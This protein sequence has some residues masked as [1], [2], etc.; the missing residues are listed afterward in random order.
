MDHTNEPF[1]PRRGMLQALHVVADFFSHYLTPIS[2]AVV[3]VGLALVIAG[4]VRAMFRDRLAAGSNEG[5]MSGI[6]ESEELQV[7]TP[8]V[9]V[10]L[11][12]QTEDDTLDR[13]L[14]PFTIIPDRPRDRV[15]SYTV[16]PGDTLFAI[17]N[18]FGIDPNT[19]FWSNSETLGDNVHMLQNGINLF[20]LP[21]DG[22]YHK[23]DGQHTLQWIADQY[24]ADVNAII[25]SEYNELSGYSPA[26]IPPWGMRI[27]VPGGRRE[28]VDW[29][30]PIIETTDQSTGQVVRGFMPGMGGSCAAGIVGSGGTGSWIPPL[31]AY[32]FTQ[33]Y[34]PGH[35][36]VD[37]A[38]PV[39]TPVL[40][41]DSGVVIFSGWTAADWGYGILVVLD[42]GN[43][44]TTYYAHLSGTNVGCGQFVPRGGTVGYVGTTGRS[45]GP[46]LHFEMRW[47]HVPDNP[48]NYIGF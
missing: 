29:R 28:I 5:G 19:L 3:I 7:E 20:I 24:Q 22:V 12:S 26:D 32:A 9:N 34:Y 15:I 14:V 17:A 33:S 43:G 10:A 4:P 35:S 38:A 41:A 25:N 46:H 27:V 2:V 1:F 48:A 8:P 37:L 40:A 23:S 42:H 39:G 16:K 6:S 11:P 31:S 47:G 21:V 44:W 18:E 45:S 30:P 36:G 13:A